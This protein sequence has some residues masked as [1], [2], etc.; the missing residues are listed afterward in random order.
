MTTI[1]AI[2]LDLDN[3]LWPVW[4]VIEAAERQTMRW[5]AEHAPRVTA[6]HTI[7]SLRE[8]RTAIIEERTDIAHDMGALRLA[9]LEKVADDH[10]YDSDTARSAYD[11][12]YEA[13]CQVEPYADVPDVL[14]AWRRDFALAAVTNGNADLQRTTLADLL[15]KALLAG[16]LGFAKPDIRIFHAACDALSSRPEETLHIGDHPEEDIEGA[17]AAGLACV[18]MNR[19]GLTWPLSSPQP[20]TVENLEQVDELLDQF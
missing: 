15:P 10:G 17:R 8:L 18:W 13:R 2:T 20:P 19:E 6:R 4:P 5:L 3:T 1:R 16:K 11:V 9:V 14:T 7:E 12:F